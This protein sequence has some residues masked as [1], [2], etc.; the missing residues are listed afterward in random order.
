MLVTKL[1][2][3]L[4]I[5]ARGQLHQNPLPYR[6][7]TPQRAD[8]IGRPTFRV[9]LEPRLAAQSPAPNPPSGMVDAFGNLPSDFG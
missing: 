6:L 2:L 7:A 9:K 8:V 1:L 3:N 4:Y 5:P